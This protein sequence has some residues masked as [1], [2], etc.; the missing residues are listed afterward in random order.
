M[1]SIAS[2]LVDQFARMVAGDG[3]ELRLI[4]VEGDMIRVAYRP[5]ADEA[6]RD[7]RCVLPMQELSKLMEETAQRRD[8][9][10]RVRLEEG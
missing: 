6:C 9:Q 7:G 10:L 1:S 5:G 3:G 4:G 2:T 8:P